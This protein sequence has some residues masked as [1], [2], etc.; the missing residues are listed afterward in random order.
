MTTGRSALKHLQQRIDG[1]EDDGSHVFLIKKYSKIAEKDA[2]VVQ[3]SQK[4]QEKLASQL[5]NSE[6]LDFKSG[7][8]P[9]RYR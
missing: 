8:S 9:D 1:G 7:Q 2:V 4:R 3:S 6:G 5:L